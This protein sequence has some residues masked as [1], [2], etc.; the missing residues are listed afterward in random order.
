[1]LASAAEL[2]KERVERRPAIIKVAEV[3]ASIDMLEDDIDRA[4]MRCS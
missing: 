3:G 1:M 2:E 4:A